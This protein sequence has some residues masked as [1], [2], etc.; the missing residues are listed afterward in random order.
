MISQQTATLQR[1]QWIKPYGCYLMS[2]VEMSYEF[3]S[4]ADPI[5]SQVIVDLYDHSISLNWMS[6]K[7]YV[8]N[9]VRIANE[10]A[11]IST[12]LG[13]TKRFPGYELQK[14]ERAV[15][16]WV[17]DRPETSGQHI[18]FIYGNYDPWP[19]SITRRDG[20]LDSLRV[21]KFSL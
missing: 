19:R 18:H 20:N 14:D 5:S 13:V 9:P 15:E 6:E 12:C 21:F 11:T 1:R 4:P 3:R 10:I 2:I 16:K 7:C 8:T 17:L